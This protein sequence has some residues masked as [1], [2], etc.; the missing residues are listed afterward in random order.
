VLH[1]LVALLASFLAFDFNN[2]SKFSLLSF[3]IFIFKVLNFRLDDLLYYLKFQFLLM[4]D[5]CRLVVSRYIVRG[6]D[7]HAMYIVLACFG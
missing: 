5:C 2:P 7:S 1:C 6:F 3:S 4:I